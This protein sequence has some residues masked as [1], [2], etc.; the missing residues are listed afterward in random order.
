MKGVNALVTGGATRLGRAIALALA[1]RGTDV[2]IHSRNS[3]A[4][5]AR[6][7]REIEELGVRA[8]AVRADLT[9]LSDT[10]ALLSKA[11]D[12]VG[13]IHL[14]VNNASVFPEST[15]SEF[16]EQDLTYNVRVNAL[17]PLWLS[18]AFAREGRKGCIVNLLDSKVVG[19]DDDHVAYHLS[20]RMLLTL[21]RMMARDFAPDIR[22]NAVAPGLVLAPE[23]KD[24]RYLDALAR[25]LPLQRH[26]SADDVTA[27]VVYLAESAF[28]TGQILFVDGGRHLEGNLYV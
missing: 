19:A 18:R 5:A 9:V 24:D 27:A 14:L 8:S 26:G 10:E 22:V 12:H 6:T 28:V 23:G 25:D 20:K 11:D 2:V 17:A 3:G 4:A 15:L 13:G 1:R 21:T 16:T 7:C